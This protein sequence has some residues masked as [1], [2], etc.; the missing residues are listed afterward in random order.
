MMRFGLS[1]LG[2]MPSGRYRYTPFFDRHGQP[3]ATAHHVDGE[4]RAKLP[5]YARASG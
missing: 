4:E 3:V 5:P 1:I 2:G